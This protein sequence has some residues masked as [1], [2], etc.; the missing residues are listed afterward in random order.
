MVRT[1]YAED[2]SSGAFSQVLAT[3]RRESAVAAIGEGHHRDG[4]LAGGGLTSL[5]GRGAIHTNKMSEKYSG[6]PITK[7]DCARTVPV[8]VGDRAPKAEAVPIPARC[9]IPDGKDVLA[10]KTPHVSFI[11]VQAQRTTVGGTPFA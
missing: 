10:S 5:T 1:Q 6:N 7:G 9:Q 4:R 3:K 11:S 2:G 8:Y